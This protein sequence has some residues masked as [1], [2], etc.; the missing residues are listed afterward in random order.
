[1]AEIDPLTVVQSTRQV[2]ENKLLAALD[3]E[4]TVAILA[5]EK[6]L[7]LLIAALEFFRSADARRMAQDYKQLRA[8]AFKKE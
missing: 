8:A 3:D 2:I 7:D 1:M 4:S 6:D 5:S